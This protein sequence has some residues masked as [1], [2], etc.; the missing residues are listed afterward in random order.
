[1][2]V[3][4]ASRA[5]KAAFVMATVVLVAL[6]CAAATVTLIA[7]RLDK[8]LNERNL[9]L[10][11]RLERFNAVHQSQLGRLRGYGHQD[12]VGALDPLRRASGLN[13][14]DSATW[15]DL[16]TAYQ[17]LNDVPAQEAALDN[18][19]DRNPRDPDLL[20]QVANFYILRD[21]PG[22]ALPLFRQVIYTDRSVTAQAINIALRA[23]NNDYDRVVAEVVPHDTEG[24]MQMLRMLW[25]RHEYARMDALWDRTLAMRQPIPTAAVGS[26]VGT[27]MARGLGEQARTA[28]QNAAMISPEVRAYYDDDNLI[29]NPSF[30][31]PLEQRGIGWFYSQQDGARLDLDATTFHSG[32]RSLMI[33]FSGQTSRQIGLAQMIPLRANQCYE[34][35]GY[36]KTDTISGIAGPRFWIQNPEDQRTYATTEP[37]DGTHSWQEFRT[38]FQPDTQVVRLTVVHDPDWSSIEGTAWFDDLSLTSAPQEKCR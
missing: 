18:A 34:F 2:Q 22:R 24:Y 33:T 9:K 7:D 13:P 31:Q 11:I 30:E 26:Y 38:Y 17:F 10:A 12:W 32:A 1:M 28:L 8:T 19:V 25:P 15:V 4:L 23:T 35:S 14:H 27:L 3:S 6:V 16:A 29:A 5:R 37:F 36:V 20:W 21:N